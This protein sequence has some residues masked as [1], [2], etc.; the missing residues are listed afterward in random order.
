MVDWLMT[1]VT[2]AMAGIAS[3][4]FKLT[5]TGQ[6]GEN[7]ISKVTALA[8]GLISLT[9]TSLFIALSA[10]KSILYH[11]ALLASRFIPFVTSSNSAPWHG[12]S[13]SLIISTLKLTALS[14]VTSTYTSV[15]SSFTNISHASKI[16]SWTTIA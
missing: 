15:T 14:V 8:D 1:L 13:V 11:F 16:F 12:S 2:S 10:S 9:A 6:V 5:T 3:D 7:S 4:L